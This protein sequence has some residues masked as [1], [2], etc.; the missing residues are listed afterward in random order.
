MKNKFKFIN[1]IT[2]SLLLLSS[3]T[4]IQAADNSKTMIKQMD[5]VHKVHQPRV[6]G[7]HLV[8]RGE[9]TFQV[10]LLSHGNH[11]CGGSIVADNWVLTAAHC[12]EGT[13]I[14]QILSGTQNLREGGQRHEIAQII[15]HPKWNYNN[16]GAGN[17]LALI[18]IKDTFDYDLE[19]VKLSNNSISQSAKTATVSGWGKTGTERGSTEL[20]EV[21]QTVI[22]DTACERMA[23]NIN[24][25]SIICAYDQGKSSC[26]GDSGGPFTVENNGET[27][28]LGI[29][30]FGPLNCDGYT[31]YTQTSNF[32]NWI[33]GYI[34][35]DTDADNNDDNATDTD[36]PDTDTC[37]SGFEKVSVTLDSDGFGIMGD[38]YYYADYG[39]HSFTSTP[40]TISMDLYQWYY[41]WEHVKS[42]TSSLTYEDEAGY[43]ALALSGK[44]G[45]KYN[46]CKK[47]P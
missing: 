14:T 8:P 1:L 7:G 24:T 16:L 35:S 38:N 3:S 27:Y 30:S 13:D 26:N 34:A 10:S 11:F 22:S 29:V 6:I 45:E 46:I 28:S 44:A 18:R 39:T 9:R 2:T 15:K 17:D 23:G 40:T 25:D 5:R 36:T 37:P 12:V 19:R 47:V 41:G 4:I 21:T 42:A 31:A 20:L 33:K 32:E 43:Y